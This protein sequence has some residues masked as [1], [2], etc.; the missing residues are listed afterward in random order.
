M[1]LS[2]FVCLLVGLSGSRITK[3]LYMNSHKILEGAG[4]GI[5]NNQS[6][7]RRERN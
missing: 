2:Q 3:E 5:R 7:D 4:L 6:D 1:C